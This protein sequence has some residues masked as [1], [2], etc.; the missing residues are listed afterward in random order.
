MYRRYLAVPTL[1]VCSLPNTQGN[2]NEAQTSPGNADHDCPQLDIRWVS[3]FVEWVLQ[4]LLR[5][6]CWGV[7]VKVINARYSICL[8][9]ETC[10]SA[11]EGHL[12]HAQ[13]PPFHNT[14]IYVARGLYDRACLVAVCAPS[15]VFRRSSRL[16]DFYCYYFRT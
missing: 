15:G 14:P 1:S 10:L 13:T 4:G 8:R 9:A 6:Q 5:C 2:L 3:R 12:E 11:S 16:R 7:V